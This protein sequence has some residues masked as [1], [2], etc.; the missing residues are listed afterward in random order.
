ML[1]FVLFPLILAIGAQNLS[2]IPELGDAI[3]GAGI[4]NVKIQP[5]LEPSTPRH[6]EEKARLLKTLD[7]ESEEWGS[8]HP[9]YELL[10]ALHSLYRYKERHF[11]D[12]DLWKEGFDGISDAQKEV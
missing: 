5:Y 8:N 4:G 9:R 12:L 1:L 2:S 10:Q 6:V 11:V 3:D 7:R